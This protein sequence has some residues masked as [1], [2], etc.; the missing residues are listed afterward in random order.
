MLKKVEVLTN[1]AVTIASLVLC[2]VLV[3]KEFFTGSRTAAAITSSTSPLSVNAK[4][5]SLL[6]TGMKISLPGV[7]WSKS[8][9]TL[10]FALSTGCHFCSESA[11]FYQILQQR[12]PKDVR[13]VAVFP[14]TIDQSDE[15]LRKLGL[16]M[17]DVV[18][19]PLASVGVSGTPTIVFVDAQG[20]V[21]GV[22]VGKLSED[23]SAR[24]LAKLQSISGSTD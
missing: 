22:W 17:G 20:T 1:I 10:V 16:A 18:Q 11:P 4:S 24:V 15:Y 9:G 21:Q 19:S 2:S 13:F 23:Q 14:Q 3:K 7:D 5:K 12:K 8:N 6:Q